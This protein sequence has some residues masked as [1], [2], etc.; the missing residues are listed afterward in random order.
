MQPARLVLENGAIFHGTAFGDVT[1][2]AAGEVVFNTAMSGYQEVMT[3]PSYKGQIVVFTAPHIGNYGINP[4]DNESDA[5]QVEGIVV[6]ECS[7]IASNWRARWTL[8]EY[9]EMH[10]KIGIQGI[11]TRRLVRILRSEGA[12]RGL[13]TT[14]PDSDEVLLERV[15]ALPLMEGADLCPL[16]TTIAPYEFV[17]EQQE[18]DLLEKVPVPQYHVV[19]VDFGVKRNILRLLAQHGCKVTVVPATTSAEDILGYDPDGVVLS[20]G[21][22]D[23]AAVT[24]GIETA[25]MLGRSGVPLLGIC[26]GHQIIALAF[27][28]TTF[29]LRF[30]HHAVNH[31]IKNLLTGSIEITSQNHGF[32]V[33]AEGLPDELE[34][35][36][37]NL[38]DGTV[39]GL[40]HR[41]YPIMSVQYHPEAAPGPHDSRYIFAAFK[42][43][44]AT[45]S[46]RKR[47]L[48]AT[49]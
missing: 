40:R 8:S 28:G 18:G 5:L 4:W 1:A 9:L 15:R 16:V 33:R 44:M 39:A 24:Y 36:H 37:I 22:G 31:P 19:V 14:A 46:A 20:N 25:R 27:G 17:P 6:Y 3:D 12:M 23:P 7:R 32:A 49:A 43:A 34:I 38:N 30:G 35:T 21:P 11:D 10:R 42:T 41:V 13:I 45:N 47:V 29:K 2:E 48:T 26:L